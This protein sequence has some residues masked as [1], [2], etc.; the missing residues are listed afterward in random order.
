MAQ[1]L[2]PDRAVAA[3]RQWRVLG[4]RAGREGRVQGR[5][6]TADV[7]F[8]MPQARSQSDERRFEAF[9]GEGDRGLPAGRVSVQVRARRDR[10]ASRTEQ[11]GVRGERERSLSS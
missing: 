10:A 7:V 2:D 1:A 8:G 5:S 3:V 11:Q 6:G 9:C 4:I